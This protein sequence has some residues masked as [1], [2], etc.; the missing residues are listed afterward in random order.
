MIGCI[1]LTSASGGDVAID[2]VGV[3]LA[4]CA[5]VAYAAYTLIMKGLLGRTCAECRDGCRFQSRC[6]DA[7]SSADW[8]RNGLVG[9]A[10]RIAVVFH[11]GLVTMA[12]AYWLFTR[13]LQRIQVA[14]AVTLT[15]AEPMTAGLL[16]LFVLG[17]H[18]NSLSFVGISLI[19]SGLAVL[20]FG[21]RSKL[22]I[23]ADFAG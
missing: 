13:G 18:L 17:E 10:A 1:A 20:A 21:G 5:G 4:I 12:L 16:G 23:P 11:L 14:T 3:I 7:C 8:S 15:L 9:N 6:S 2:L 19:V 22:E